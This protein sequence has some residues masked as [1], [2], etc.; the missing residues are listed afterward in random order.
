MLVT[1]D[2]FGAVG[3]Q[4]VQRFTLSNAANVSVQLITLGAIITSIKVPD[5]E[6]RQQDVVL[7]FD[8]PQGEK[9]ALQN[10]VYSVHHLY[11]QLG[12]STLSFHTT[13]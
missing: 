2:V 4:Q 7:G 6:G 11:T 10:K 12:E 1:A 13:Q 3:G 8:G 9:H 5:R